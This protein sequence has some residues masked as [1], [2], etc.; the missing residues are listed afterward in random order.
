MTLIAPNYAIGSFFGFT[1]DGLFQTEADVANHKN[2]N[3]ELLQP[4]ARPGDI[5]F[6]DRN[7]DGIIDNNDRGFIGDPTPD[8]SYGFTVNAAWKGFDLTFFGQ[9]VAGRR[10]VVSTSLRLTIQKK[11]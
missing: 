10:S 11:H 7:G 1:T 6:V 4:S 9:G 5:R 3:G 2:H 8:W